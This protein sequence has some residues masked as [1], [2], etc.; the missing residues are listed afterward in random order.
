MVEAMSDLPSIEMLWLAGKATG[1][2]VLPSKVPAAYR[3]RPP[4]PAIATQPKRRK[5]KTLI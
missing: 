4:F 5:V 1:L 2:G 3:M